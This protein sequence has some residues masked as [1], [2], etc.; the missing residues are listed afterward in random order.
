MFQLSEIW[1]PWNQLSCSWWISLW[2]MLYGRFWSPHTGLQKV[3]WEILITLHRLPK[4]KP[5]AWTVIKIT[6]MWNIEKKKENEIIKIKVTQKFT[7]LEAKT[8]TRKINLKLLSQKLFN[9]L[10]ANLK[11]KKLL[12]SL[13]KKILSFTKFKTHYC[14]SKT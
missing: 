13:M 8:N 10:I 6:S 14:Y 2:K 9:T 1:T 4:T 5:S 7:Y 11:Q 3:V 12:L